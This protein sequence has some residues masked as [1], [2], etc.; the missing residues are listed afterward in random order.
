MGLYSVIRDELNL[1]PESKDGRFVAELC[2]NYLVG[3]ISAYDFQREI[4]RIDLTRT[5]YSGKTFRLYMQD[6]AYFIL[7]MKFA[8]LNAALR[9]GRRLPSLLKSFHIEPDDIKL[10]VSLFKRQA[11]RKSFCASRR[12]K[13]ISANSISAVDMLQARSAFMD[14]NDDIQ[15]HIK[16]RVYKKLQF[17]IEAENLEYSDLTCDVLEKALKIYYCMLPTDKSAAHITN[18]LRR[19]CSNHV[20]NLV[21]A[22][23][24]EKRGRKI[25][26]GADGFGGNKYS[27]K[28]ISE[29]QAA[30]YID[31]DQNFDLILTCGTSSGDDK[32]IESDIFMGKLFEKFKGDKLT[33][34]KILCGQPNQKFTEW[35]LKNNKIKAGEDNEDLQN[36]VQPKTF[37]ALIAKFLRV[38]LEA[39]TRF[40]DRIGYILKTQTEYA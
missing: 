9:F 4:K 34:L 31:N 3:A 7:N 30:R 5:K 39:F 20:V 33:A 18:Y 24:T 21:Y 40:V 6:R 27:L 11:F 26:E 10:L 38:K 13:S 8:I 22:A 19:S 16:T 17:V 29:N 12:V 1:A 28:V 14:Y 2:I 36:R 23:T 25:N 37:F 15:K 35:L 32:Q